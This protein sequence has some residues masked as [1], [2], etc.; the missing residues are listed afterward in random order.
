[1]KIPIRFFYD[2]CVSTALLLRSCRAIRVILTKISNRSGMGV[3][4]KTFLN[5]LLSIG[6][7]SF[8]SRRM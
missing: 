4:G 2:L 5:A 7:C 6:W 3:F 8:Y 1:M